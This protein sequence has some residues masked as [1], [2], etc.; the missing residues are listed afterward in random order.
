MLPLALL[1]PDFSAPY[2]ASP[3]LPYRRH[4]FWYGGL[5]DTLGLS[6]VPTLPQI[7]C[8]LAREVG[9]TWARQRGNVAPA[10]QL[11]FAAPQGLSLAALVAGDERL[12]AAHE[13]AVQATL[14]FIRCRVG[15]RARISVELTSP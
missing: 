4:S 14:D 13:D 8:L 5:Q 3:Y 9:G 6:G 11:T 10:L 12:I 2:L 1:L 7:Q 15:Y